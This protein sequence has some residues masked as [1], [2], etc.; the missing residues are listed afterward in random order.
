MVPSFSQYCSKHYVLNGIEHWVFYFENGYG[1]SVV[2]GDLINGYEL[3][4]LKYN[5]AKDSWELCYDTVITDDV[6]SCLDENGVIDI[7]EAV[8]RM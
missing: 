8:E 3:A 4:V 5:S 7:L 6:I 1:A 2:H